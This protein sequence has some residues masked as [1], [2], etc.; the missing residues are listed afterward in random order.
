MRLIDADALLK[1]LGMAE[2][3]GKCQNSRNA[4]FCAL[5]S[6][7]VDVCEAIT[8]LPTVDAVPVVRCKECKHNWGKEHSKFYN[9]E[10]IVCD[11]WATDGLNDDDFCSYGERSDE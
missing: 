9:P 4:L 6:E 2:E 10:D 5:S 7:M 1:T 8:D 11:Y 3:C